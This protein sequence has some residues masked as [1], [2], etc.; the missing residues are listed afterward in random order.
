M[1]AANFSLDGIGG[2][3]SGGGN[4]AF[5]AVGVGAGAGVADGEGGGVALLLAVDEPLD[6]PGSSILVKYRKPL[7][8]MAARHTTVTANGHIQF[9]VADTGSGSGGGLFNCGVE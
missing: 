3:G 5:P 4:A 1:S 8:P 9:G 2:G 7:T 6:P